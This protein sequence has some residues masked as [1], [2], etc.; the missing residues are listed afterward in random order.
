MFNMSPRRHLTLILLLLLAVS[1]FA[2]Q[3]LPLTQWRLSCPDPADTAFSTSLVVK[4]PGC[5]HTDLFDHGLIPDPFYGTNE[6][7]LQWL[8][9]VPCTYTCEFW[10][11]ELPAK[12]NIEL[13]LA[14]VTGYAEVFLNGQPLEHQDHNNV[15]DNAYRTWR[16]PLDKKIR[17]YNLIEVRFTPAQKIIDQRKAAVPYALPE[18]RA[19]LR[20]PPYQSGWDWGPKLTTCGIMGKAAIE[21]YSLARLHSPDFHATNQNGAI[22]DFCYDFAKKLPYGTCISL[23]INDI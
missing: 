8:S 23:K 20:M 10:R 15:M 18:E 19:W 2:Q 16:F 17:T 7:S 1:G 21:S 3:T 22:Y 13:V 6:E 5:L 4:V 12:K 9:Y 14:G 11:D